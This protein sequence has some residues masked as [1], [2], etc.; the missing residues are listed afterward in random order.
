MNGIPNRGLARRFA[1]ALCLTAAA[2]LAPGASA[3]PT[4]GVTTDEVRIGVHLD[5]SGPITFWG[6]PMRNGHTMRVEEQ[7]EKGGVHGRKIRL[8]VE[9]N[10]YDPKKGVLA[11]QKLIQ[12]DRVFA[13]AGVLGTPIVLSSMQTALDAGV[14]M[15]FPGSPHRRTF[16]PFHKLKFSMAAPYDD[17]VKAGLKW[18]AARKASKRL[19]IIYQD[20]DFGK[21]LRDAWAAQAKILNIE[22]AA[23][24]SYKR[25][26]TSFSSQVAR[27]KQANVD[28][29]GIATV[30][31]ET[32][33]VATEVKKLGWQV[34]M[35]GSAAAC[36]GAVAALGK[37]LVE[38]IYVVCQYV[39]F[40][41]AGETPAVKDWM[42]RYKK[43]FN[44]DADV[45]AAISYDIMDLTIQGMQNAG[46]DL[47]VDR[48][49]TGIE[50]IKGWQSVFGAPAQTYGANQHLGTKDAVMTQITA[51]KFKRVSGPISD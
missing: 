41:Y 3:Q 25:G 31:R 20:D 33:G 46:R 40:D 49:I 39:P 5:L 22:L 2:A 6:V 44:Q 47:N 14:P 18:V 17:Q 48:L 4:Q 34:E 26:D 51:G 16:E 9:D 30:V 27:M 50:A 35:L 1:A 19:G 7:N 15:L 10:G 24:A 21:D 11:T 8:L 42:D 45:S 37:D 36:N 32:V 13:L 43:R 23:E 12:Q 29:I 28:L 38:G